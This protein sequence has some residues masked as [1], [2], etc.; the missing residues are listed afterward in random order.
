[1]SDSP[2]RSTTP[3]EAAVAGPGSIAARQ[4]DTQPRPADAVP[5]MPQQRASTPAVGTP[6]ASDQTDIT[7]GAQ[8]LSGE[9]TNDQM[10]GG[11][12]ATSAERAPPDTQETPDPQGD[13]RDP[14]PR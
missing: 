13:A 11:S 6:G 10:P 4:A 7:P 9:A 1:M 5:P 8:G 14:L 12:T 2:D 3:D